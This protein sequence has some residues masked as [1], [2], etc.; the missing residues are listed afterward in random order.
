[1]CRFSLSVALVGAILLCAAPAAAW[2]PET[3]IRMVDEAVRF[4]PGSLRRALESNREPLLRGMLEPMK[5][6]DGPE[7]RPPWA[8]GSLNLSLERAA[9]D[10]LATLAEQTPFDEIAAHFGTVAHYVLDAGFPP[11]MSDGDGAARFTHFAEFCESRRER[12]PLVFYGHDD[13]ALENHDYRAFG[14]S[15]M[16]RA[17]I[18]DRELSRAYVAAGDPP[19]PSAFDDRSV[20]FAVGSLC[21]SRNVTDIVRIWLAVWNQAGGDMGRTPYSERRP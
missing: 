2:A 11:G 13:P 8:E 4:M 7:H 16:T 5:Q 18:E 1:M 21:Y 15:V 14:V 12:F 17:M 20:P 19:D 10:L 9:Q 3:R 6:E